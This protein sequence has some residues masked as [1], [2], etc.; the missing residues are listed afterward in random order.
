MRKVR[1]RLTWVG[2]GYSKE[3]RME[4]GW[5]KRRGSGGRF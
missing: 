2:R 1:E 5:G 4:R 3:R